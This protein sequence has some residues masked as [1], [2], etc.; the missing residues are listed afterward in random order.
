MTST[1]SAAQPGASSAAGPLTVRTIDQAQHTAFLARHRDA[2][3]LQNPRWAQV[4]IDWQGRSLGVFRGADLVG[5][6]LVLTRRLP[7]PARVPVLGRAFL[8]YIA[9]GPVLD[10]G[11]SLTD[12]LTPIVAALKKDGAFLVRI[13]PPGVVRTWGP[14][15]VRAALADP[16]VSLLTDIPA[17]ASAKALKTQQELRAAGWRAPEVLAE[18]AAGQ[19]MFQARIP[20]AGLDVDGVLARMTSS[21]RKSTRRSLRN[22]LV[23]VRA[24][25]DRLDDWQALQDETAARDDFRA[26]PQEYFRRMIEQLGSS[27]LVDVD[28][29][30]AEHEGVPVAGSFHLRQGDVCWRPYSASSNRERKRDAPRFLQITQIADDVASG[31]LW[32]D[33]GGVPGTVD[34]DHPLT[35]LTRFKTLQGADIV[36]THGEWDLPLNKPLAAAFELYMSRR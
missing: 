24:G 4:K 18:F 15:A 3:F 26:R 29:Y 28:F 1:P 21:S 20:L 2:S 6:A 7:V 9:E 17:E 33:L 12:A 13:A 31:A 11:V 32:L 23:A 34:A 35:G 22:D 14:E 16:E 25:V 30:L 19:P 36:Q 27:E 5:A 10:E 8:A